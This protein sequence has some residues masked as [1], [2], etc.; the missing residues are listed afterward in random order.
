MKQLR[1]YNLI[2]LSLAACLFTG[3]QQA[4]AQSTDIDDPTPV[5]SN[6]IDGEG[7]GKAETFYYSFTA[8]KGDLKV[9]L[10]AKTDY[11][12]V[13]MDAALTDED[14]KELLKISSIATDT[15]KREVMTKHFV[16]ETKVILRIRLPKDD[17]LKLLTYK[18]KLEG[19]IKIDPPPV[20]TEITPGEQTV[21]TPAP[22]DPGAVTA[23]PPAEASQAAGQPAS[24][25]TLKE[26]AKAK[27]QAKK[28]L[29]KIID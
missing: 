10:D 4:I 16:R 28:I 1:N 21:E 27:A 6:V 17:H 12:S 18:I 3:A 14:G 7:D 19:A 9:T 20:P 5:T 29:S 2:M 26:K 24:A 11:Y 8:T 15:G 22:T 23:T 13:T 25:L